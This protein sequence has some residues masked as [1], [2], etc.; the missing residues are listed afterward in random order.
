MTKLALPEIPSNDGIG[1]GK[2]MILAS[3]LILWG[4]SFSHKAYCNCHYRQIPCN[5]LFMSFYLEKLKN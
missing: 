1:G 5:S 4:K 3:M 2:L